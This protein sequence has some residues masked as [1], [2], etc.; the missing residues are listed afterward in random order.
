[1]VETQQYG[2]HKCMY[3]SMRQFHRTRR[4]SLLQGGQAAPQ[5]VLGK[6]LMCGSDGSVLE[7]TARLGCS[8]KK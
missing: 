3:D 8:G 7:F 6:V 5:D 1:M 2:Q 4:L